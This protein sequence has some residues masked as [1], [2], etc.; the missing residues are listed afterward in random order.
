MTAHALRV[1]CATWTFFVVQSTIASLLETTK[2]H[3][4]WVVVDDFGWADVS[5]RS[6]AQTLTPNL[7]N[8]RRSAVE[9]TNLQ[10]YKFCTP[11]RSSF[12]TGRIPFHTLQSLTNIPKPPACATALQLNYTL[13]PEL[14]RSQGYYCSHVGKWHLGAF[15]NRYLPTARGFHESLAYLCITGGY[16][17][18]TQ[19]GSL[20]QCHG[21][22][23][24]DLWLN[25]GPARQLNG[26]YDATLYTTFAIDVIQ[27]HAQ[28]QDKAPLYLH[29]EYHVVHEPIQ[30]PVF[31]QDRY[32]HVT[33]K[34]RKAYC[35]MISAMDDGV[36]NVT[37]ALKKYGFFDN[38]VLLVTSDNGAL[39][40]AG[41]C[42]SNWPL[43]GGKKSFFAGGIQ[44][45]AL[46]H[47]P[48][49]LPTT[50]AGTVFSGLSHA[51]DFYP[52]LAALG[53]VGAAELAD[54]GPFPVDGVD[55]WP[56]LSGTQQGN[57]H[58]E[59][60]VSGC[61]QGTKTCNGALF[62]GDLKLIVGKQTPA[63]WYPVPNGTTTSVETVH[64][65]CSANGCIFNM[66]ADPHERTNLATTEPEL[67]ARLLARLSQLSNHTVPQ[68]PPS[69][70]CGTDAVCAAV[71]QNK[72][73]FGPWDDITPSHNRSC[74]CPPAV[75][76]HFSTG[77][78]LVK[79]AGGNTSTC[80]QQCCD[81]AGCGGWVFTSYEVKSSA[82]CPAGGTCCY[83]RQGAGLG[84]LEPKA[85]CTAGLMN[86]SSIY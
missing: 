6:G 8:L 13:L 75:G 44:G 45:V 32:P 21:G 27:R 9:L 42:G 52:T 76:Y 86:C 28:R 16:D 78:L 7:D 34:C 10:M 15:A 2:P 63:G 68:D 82:P 12:L 24:V 80:R 64:D 1:L 20:I 50:A 31:Y 67:L 65:D 41:G 33:N 36:G 40:D 4:I 38:A 81:T 51:A 29:L 59:L 5:W 62:V 54:S 61:R 18:F 22:G 14:L 55:L 23:G 72:G 73:F 11:T 49:L 25:D 43:R 53:G 60:L 58:D 84:S 35:G 37:R 79:F 70:H 26:T 47:S 30:S 83:L 46:V 57:P 69:T 56:F 19:R 85:N 3:I 66:T 71:V 17:H 39:V 74:T 48:S 77:G